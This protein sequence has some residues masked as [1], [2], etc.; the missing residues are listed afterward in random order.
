MVRN[1]VGTLVDVGTGRLTRA[2]VAEILASADRT[3]A[4]Q[5]APAHGLELVEVLYTGTRVSFG[6]GSR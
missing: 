5:T 6:S 3:R 4:G 2:Q 1:I